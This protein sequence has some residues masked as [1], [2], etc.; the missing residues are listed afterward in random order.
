[1]IVHID[2]DI[3]ESTRDTLKFLYPRVNSGGSIVIHDYPVHRGVKKA[4]DDYMKKRGSFTGEDGKDLIPE[5]TEADDLELARKLAYIIATAD[6][7]E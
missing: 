5:R 2:V 1:M 4:V 7:K 6:L 3:Y